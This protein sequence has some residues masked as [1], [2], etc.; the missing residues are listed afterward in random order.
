MDRPTAEALFR[1]HHLSVFRFL[2][3]MTGD[4]ALAE[5][6]TQDTFVRVIRGLETYDPRDRDLAWL[7]RIARRLL[8]DREREARRRP[9]LVV[10]DRPH[11]AASST[12]LGIEI[13]EA[14]RLLPAEE[15]EAFLLREQGGLGYEEIGTLAGATPDAVRRFGSSP[16]GWA[17][18]GSKNC[19]PANDENYLAIV[20]ALLDAGADRKSSINKWNEPPENLGSEKVDAFL[21][22]WWGC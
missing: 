16:L 22:G 13:D 12:H 11:A 6:I 8:A 4:A 5:D 2:R 20:R 10:E 3:R 9:I 7:F 15:R 18:H 1:L 14:L 17:A 21:K 19:G